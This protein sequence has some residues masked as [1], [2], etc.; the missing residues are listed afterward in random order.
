MIT[1]VDEIDK[2][3]LESFRRGKTISYPTDPVHTE[4][5][6]VWVAAGILE[7]SPADPASAR[8]VYKITAQGSELAELLSPLGNQTDTLP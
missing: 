7:L 2:A 3:L 6:D 1:S 5:L 8:P 4:K